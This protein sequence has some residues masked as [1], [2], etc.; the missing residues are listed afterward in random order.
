MGLKYLNDISKLV[1]KNDGGL[2][3]IDYGYTEQEMINTLQGISNHKF[4]NI[5]YNIGNVD[6]THNINFELLK[7][8]QIK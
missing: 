1:K 3:I 7:D 5:L 4:A 6:I 8:L 2:L